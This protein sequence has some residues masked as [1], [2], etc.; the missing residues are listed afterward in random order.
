MQIEPHVHESQIVRQ[1]KSLNQGDYFLEYGDTKVLVCEE[2]Q[3][4]TAQ[5]IKQAMNKAILLHDKGSQ[6]AGT[7]LAL[8]AQIHAQPDQWASETLG[9][10]E[11]V[12]KP[13]PWW[14]W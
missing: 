1:Y 7:L 6:D 2:R 13:K 4:P 14:R 12:T 3:S 8:T 11:E 5:Q 10:V 9:I